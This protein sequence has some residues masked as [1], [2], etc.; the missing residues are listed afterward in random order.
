[1]TTRE[2]LLT[3]P[4]AQ[5]AYR[6]S[7]LFNRI[8]DIVDEGERRSDPDPVST[9]GRVLAAAMDGKAEWEAAALRRAKMTAPD[10]FTIIGPAPQ[11]R[12]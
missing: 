1:M 2:R 5:A 10:I 8:V 6:N 11:W 4:E 12:P 7:V 9:L 3:S